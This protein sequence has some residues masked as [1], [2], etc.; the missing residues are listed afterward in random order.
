MKKKVNILWIVLHLV[1]I[2]VFNIIVFLINS[3]FTSTFWVSYGFI[4]FSYLMLVLS[5]TKWLKVKNSVVLGY[6]TIYLSY[7]YFIVSFIVS[8]IFMCFKNVDFLISFIPQLVITGLYTI[9]YVSNLLANEYTVSNQKERQQNIMYIKN[10]AL[11]IE[12]LISQSTDTLF[13]KKLEKLYDS[14]RSSQVK[15]HPA[16]AGIEEE[17]MLRIKDL[18]GR[19]HSNEYLEANHVMDAISRLLSDRNSRM[20]F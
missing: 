9:V 20:K 16:L 8:V 1:F 7:L 17:I 2:V 4:H 12:L 6:P 14:F 19:V 13:K 18:N 10:A 11:Q 15:S 3:V 5:T